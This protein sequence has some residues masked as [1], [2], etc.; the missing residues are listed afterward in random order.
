MKFKN[1]TSKFPIKV[2]MLKHG[3]H[4]VHKC[5]YGQYRIIHIILEGGAIMKIKNIYLILY[6]GTNS[7]SRYS[8]CLVSY[9]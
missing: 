5:G 9:L 7:I 1:L 2:F 3:L 8:L 4:R 6:S